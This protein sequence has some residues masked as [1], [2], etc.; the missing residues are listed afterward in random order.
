M[1]N[2][3]FTQDLCDFALREV[4][5]PYRRPNTV[6]FSLALRAID[7]A[8]GSTLFADHIADLKSAGAMR[9]FLGREGLG[10]LIYRMSKAGFEEIPVSHMTAGD[11]GF[12]GGP[13]FGIGACLVVGRQVLTSHPDTG[14]TLY[15]ADGLIF[16]RAVRLKKD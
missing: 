10:G 12:T 16:V 5:Q 6:C 2:P 7:A 13:P 4:G 15:P 8:S 3:N 9:N 1:F 11:I 14:V